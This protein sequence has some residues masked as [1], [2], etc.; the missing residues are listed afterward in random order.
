M[1]TVIYPDKR[2]FPCL[3]L[4]QNNC[5]TVISYDGL[6]FIYSWL[7]KYSLLSVQYSKNPYINGIDP[8]G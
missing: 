1:K 6:Y 2:L 5:Q 4:T 8:Q 7:K 3:D